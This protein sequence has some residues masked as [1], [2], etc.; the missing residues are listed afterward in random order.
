MVK[1]VKP[2][3]DHLK[4]LLKLMGFKRNSSTQWSQSID[5]YTVIVEIGKY[6]DLMMMF[7]DNLKEKI[8]PNFGIFGEFYDIVPEPKYV[9]HPGR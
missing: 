4:V 5:R 1:R 7:Y 6:N 8:E 3:L 2:E 9:P